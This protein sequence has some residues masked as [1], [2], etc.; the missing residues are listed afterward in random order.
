[1][2]HSSDLVRYCP[3]CGRLHPAKAKEYRCC[4]DSHQSQVIRYDIAIQALVGFK[5]KSGVLK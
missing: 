2:L 3:A 5:Y 4:P 1:M